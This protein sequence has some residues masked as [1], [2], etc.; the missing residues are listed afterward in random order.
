M[1]IRY[2]L[3]RMK[4]RFKRAWAVFTFS[5]K[6]KFTNDI[7]LAIKIVTRMLSKP[8]VDIRFSFVNS[9]F[10]VKYGHLYAKISEQS[11][12]V[13]NGRYAYELLLPP[14]AG[15]ELLTKMRA[16]NERKLLKAEAEHR[17]R[18]D[19]SLQNIYDGLDEQQE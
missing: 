5:K 11:I 14:Q 16:L 10:H 3:A 17:K 2:K 8:E 1:K 18:I 7:D 19:R 13:I 4:V 15:Y 9:V 6:E 12:T